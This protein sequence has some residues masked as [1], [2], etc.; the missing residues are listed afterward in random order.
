MVCLS[1]FWKLC[2]CLIIP[3]ARKLNDILL[4]RLFCLMANFQLWNML[5]LAQAVKI[6]YYLISFPCRSI[7]NVKL[8]F[9]WNRR[10]WVLLLL[11]LCAFP[12]WFFLECLPNPGNTLAAA[13]NSVIADKLPPS[14]LLDTCLFAILGIALPQLGVSYQRG[15]CNI[16]HMWIFLLHLWVKSCKLVQY[17]L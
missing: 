5:V 12:S 7:W 3:A 1:P 9:G 4:Q 13:W 15:F 10:H 14:L 6:L 16:M 2:Q 17:Y 8:S 11:E